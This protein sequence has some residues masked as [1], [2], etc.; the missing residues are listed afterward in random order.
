M[1]DI[2]FITFVLGM[3]VGLDVATAIKRYVFEE[4][5]WVEP[6]IFAVLLTLAATYWV[7]T[8]QSAA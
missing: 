6:V 8:T 3:V 7:I 5:D 4:P 1:N 2:A